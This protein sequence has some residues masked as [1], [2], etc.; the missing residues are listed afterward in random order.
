MTATQTPAIHITGAS[1]CGVTTLGR[2]VAGALGALHIDADD[3]YWLPTDPPYLQKRERSARL[4]LL[5]ES[6]HQAGERGWVLTGSILEWG[7][8]LISLFT[9]VVFLTAPTE[10]RLRRL[11]AREAQRFGARI[12][13]G[14]DLLS[15]HQ[16]FL[17]WAAAYDAG[18][19]GGR[20]RARHEEWLT[21]MQAPVVR[22]D[23]TAPY[24]ELLGQVLEQ[25]KQLACGYP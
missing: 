2:S 24:E 13:P 8:S 21:R 15:T 19:C 14:G 6:F 9:L 5:D 1:G 11:K 12:D 17:E 4:K 16:A 25:I 7:D 20:T 3:V 23:A 22:L 18:T 10:L